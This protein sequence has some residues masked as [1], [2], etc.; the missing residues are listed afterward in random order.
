[1]AETNALA[2][3]YPQP[4]AQA[5]NILTDPSKALGLLGQVNA[6]TLQ[7]QQIRANQGVEDLYKGAIGPDGTP[8]NALVM[9]RVPNLGVR[10]MEGAS[11]LQ[12]QE[13]QRIQNVTAQLQQD[14]SRRSI[15]DSVIGALPPNATHDQVAHAV[16][17]L[18]RKY[19]PDVIP[20]RMINSTLNDLRDP[21]VRAERIAAARDRVLGPTGLASPIEG[22]PSPTG[23]KQTTTMGGFLRGGSSTPLPG[24]VTPPAAPVSAFP[25]MKTTLPAGSDKSIALSQE[26]LARAGNFGQEIFPWQQALDKLKNLGAGGT[27]PGSKGRQEFESFLYS[28]SPAI[29]QM[30]GVDPQKVKNYAEAEKYLTNATQQRAASFGA[31]TDLGLS[32]ALT[33]SPS[34]H[35]NDLAA[36]DVTRAAIGLRRMEHVQTLANAS[37]PVNYAS[38]ISKFAAKQNPAAYMIDVM[39]PEQVARLNSTL[40]GPER[41]KFNKS[42][43]LAIK[44]GVVTPPGGNNAQP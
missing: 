5:Q 34:V 31:H 13:G 16:T 15:L 1:M 39:T 27:G 3:L 14:A 6:L 21:K 41:D 25:T 28:A 22:P 42:L 11:T 10:S 38:N 24:E 30:L 19:G 40:K 4:P 20:S 18:S 44:Y 35:I 32:T 9:S 29:S 8:D 26:H 17:S 23:E 33:G 2:G 7:G 36:A 43:A 37:D 12:A